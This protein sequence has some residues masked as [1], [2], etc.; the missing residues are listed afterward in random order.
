[1]AEVLAFVSANAVRSGL[2][3]FRGDFSRAQR[4]GGFRLQGAI[5]GVFSG[6][7]LERVQ[8]IF[9]DRFVQ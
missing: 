2:E 3:V 6:A 8:L 1:M 7:G 4:E 5:G 9:F